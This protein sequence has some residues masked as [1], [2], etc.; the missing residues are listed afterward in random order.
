MPNLLSYTSIVVSAKYTTKYLQSSVK[1]F[2]LEK[3]IILFR[4]KDKFQIASS[5]SI[6]L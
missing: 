5:F 3:R 4:E 6:N 2:A 1:A